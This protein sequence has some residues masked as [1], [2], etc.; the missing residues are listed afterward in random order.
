M[1]GI[2]DSLLRDDLDSQL[3]L[4]KLPSENEYRAAC[5]DLFGTGQLHRF[6][7]KYVRPRLFPLRHQVARQR[8]SIAQR[9]IK[10]EMINA[11][12]ERALWNRPA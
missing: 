2:P 3:G 9:I 6:W 8:F 12:F 5:D 10:Q 11:V 7:C 4:S 1:E